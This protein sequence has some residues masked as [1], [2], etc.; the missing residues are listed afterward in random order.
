M[1]D[2][3]YDAI[4]FRMELQVQPDIFTCF[5]RGRSVQNGETYIYVLNLCRAA[6][7]KRIYTFLTFN[8]LRAA[9]KSRVIHVSSSP[10]FY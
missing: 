3:K 8:G 1:A 7:E 10:T 2:I 9:H 5:G 6:L 4:H